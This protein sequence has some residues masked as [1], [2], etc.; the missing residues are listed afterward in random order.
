MVKLMSPRGFRPFLE[1]VRQAGNGP[2]CMTLTPRDLSVQPL[3]GGTCAVTL[4]IGTLPSEAPTQPAMF[5]RRTF[6]LKQDG[7]VWRIMHLHA[8]NVRTEP[9]GEPS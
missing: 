1:R 3:G 6:A 4:H 7:T 8:S 5:S 2:P 9:P